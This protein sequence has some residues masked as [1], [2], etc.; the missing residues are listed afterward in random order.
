MRKSYKIVQYLVS[1]NM[2]QDTCN[3]KGGLYRGSLVARQLI[4]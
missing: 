1:K 4:H 2:Y 3:I